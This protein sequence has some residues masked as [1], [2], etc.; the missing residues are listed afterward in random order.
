MNIPSKLSSVGRLTRSLSALETWGFG[1]SGLLLWLGTAPGMHA[2][3]GDQA[4]WVW[5]PG[6][7]VGMMLNFQ[8]KRLGWHAQNVSGG[9][10]NYTTRLLKHY[11]G[12]ARYAAIGYL[13]GWVSVP[14]I[15]AILLT[16]LIKTNLEPLGIAC[17]ELGFKIGFALLPF[18]VAFSGA[19]ALGVLHLFFVFPAI[20]LLLVFCTQG[21]GWLA[22]APDS[23]GFLP[24]VLPG[25]TLA[26]W[27]KWFF[28]A[29][30]AVYGCETASSFVADSRRPT[31]TLKAL[32][33]AAWLLPIVYLG[34]S[35]VLMRLST[36]SN[37]GS[38]AFLELAA[39]AQPF[40]GGAA[41]I[42]VTF[43]IASGCLL[44][45]ATAVCNVPRI[46]HQLA[47]DG[48]IAPV[49]AVVSRRGVLGPALALT[50]LLNLLCLIWGDI[51]RIVMVTGTG[52]LVAMIGI[53][54][55]LWLRRG[56]P[57]V[58]WPRWSLGFALVETAVLIGGG[59]A[60]GWQDLLLGLLLPIAL[61]GA[62][63]A[64]GRLPIPQLRPDWW[65]QQ[66]QRRSG[67]PIPDLMLMQI[68]VLILLVC[69]ST[70]I[71]WMVRAFL[72]GLTFGN[73]ANLL[74]VLLLAIA[75]VGVAIAC[76]TSLPQIAAVVEAR[77][78]AEHLFIVASDA[79]VVVDEQGTIRQANPAARDLFER[80]RSALLG[81]SLCELLPTLSPEPSDWAI[82]S[83]QPLKL[84]AQEVRTVEISL[85]Q[86]HHQDFTLEYVVI[87]RDI[88]EA[89][90]TETCLRE[91]AEQLETALRYVQ[92]TQSKLVQTEKMSGLGQLVA[93]VAHEINNPVNF[94][95]GNL[96]HAQEYTQDLLRLVQL[97][98]QVYPDPA[99]EIQA[100]ETAIDLEFILHD[101]PK[102]LTSMR[103]GTERIKQIVASLRTFS[104][105]DEAEIKAVNLH[106]GIDSTLLILQH[107]LKA[108]SDQ[109]EIQIIKNYGV[110]P[111][112]ECYP[113]QLNQ[114]FMN[115]LSNAIDALEERH[116]PKNQPV[117]APVI[118]ITTQAIGSG[119]RIEFADNGA[120]IPAE[121]Q[122][123][124]FDPFFTTKPV[125]KGTGLGLSISYDI[126]ADKHQGQLRCTSISGQGATFTIEIPLRQTLQC[127]QF[128]N[129]GT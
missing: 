13:L 74:V 81:H 16:D 73:N 46:L 68:C 122:A 38:N 112:V 55:G 26:S 106:D 126:V 39:A 114:V 22:I 91:Q 125:G 8:V 29:V 124:L 21:L 105:M 56:Q 36:A 60:W 11:P 61:L 41:P 52:Y 54:L 77:E 93:G 119:V 97:Y 2:E 86:T 83:E 43:L 37:L 24:S 109:P 69:G 118:Q 19:R 34:G 71:G 120:G 98:Q 127:P 113:G 121:I 107:R 78:Q 72:D 28:V 104:R 128:Q 14:P 123:R 47:L 17:P 10:P 31:Q 45:S 65:M 44:S 58:R 51:A 117:L 1:L 15:N 33:I 76:W 50:G 116:S 70:G 110:L 82:Q 129:S 89:K 101:L 67:C 35:W 84:P 48:H 95:Y 87:L 40:W 57:E 32:S 30:Y 64:I 27:A 6:A 108:K 88:S 53:H 9:T 94:I 85:S 80:T 3:L 62:N 92:Q 42:L 102:L 103:V 23:P 12:L 63:A 20:G 96:N 59:L 49:F 5:L 111:L 100:E 18:I 99:A 25:I 4:I 79:I 90:R 115:L 75:F 66:Y 7:I